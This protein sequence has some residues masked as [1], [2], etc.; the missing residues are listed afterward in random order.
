MGPR[1]RKSLGRP[2][3][4]L[5]GTV[6]NAHHA[7]TVGV[8]WRS[9]GVLQ[10]KAVIQSHIRRSRSQKAFANEKILR[11]TASAVVAFLSLPL[12]VAGS[13]YQLRRLGSEPEQLCPLRSGDPQHRTVM[14]RLQEPGISTS[15]STATKTIKVVVKITMAGRRCSELRKTIQRFR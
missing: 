6:N 12:T 13:L 8:V 4:Q 2:A 14:H 7:V 11:S 9:H 5:V 10:R 15:N 1:T 3:L